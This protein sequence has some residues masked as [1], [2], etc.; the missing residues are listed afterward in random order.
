VIG[1]ELA[2]LV[3]AWSSAVECVQYKHAMCG[4]D[5]PQPLTAEQLHA[6]RSGQPV[7][8]GRFGRGISF[9][10]YFGYGAEYIAKHDGGN[11]GGATPLLL[12]WVI[13]GNVYPVTESPSS[14]YEEHLHGKPLKHGFDS[15]Y[16][17]LQA[18]SKLP[19]RNV[20]DTATAD[21]MVIFEPANVCR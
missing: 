4:F 9:T 6:I 11:D 19:I 13:M 21:E 1:C 10:Q 14:A 15:H 8:Y 12:S 3:L 20:S 18:E 16:A 2:N 5:Q 7:D 17:L